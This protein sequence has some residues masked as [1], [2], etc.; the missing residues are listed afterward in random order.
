MS[1][2]TT[3][4]DAVLERVQARGSFFSARMDDEWIA[5]AAVSPRSLSGLPPWEALLLNSRTDGPAKYVLPPGGDGLALRAEI[6][7]DEDVD[8]TERVRQACSGM[9]ELAAAASARSADSEEAARPSAAGAGQTSA[10]VE[11]SGREGELSAKPDLRALVTDAGWSY[12]ARSTHTL[13]VDLEVRLQFQQAMLE[14]HGAGCR[15]R[16][17]LLMTRAPSAQ[18]RAAIGTLLLTIAGLVRTVR[19]GAV[20]HEEEVTLFFEVDFPGGV[21]AVELRHGLA[22][23]AVA[24]RMAG[25]EA[26]VLTDEQVARAYLAA[27]FRAATSSQ[28]A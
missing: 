8:V 11:A 3:A 18:S 4:P 27:R 24:C 23:L 14:A 28:P 15:A 9:L 21:T 17:V 19:A 12:V 20:S 10:A 1:A 2:S 22:A 25:R 6:L 7:A 5:L 16:A 13:A 26:R